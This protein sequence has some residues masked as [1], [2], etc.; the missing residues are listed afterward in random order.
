MVDET[1]ENK[2]VSIW[3]HAAQYMESVTNAYRRDYW[4]YQPT[5]F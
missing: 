1:R 2:L 3:D 5:N 4:K